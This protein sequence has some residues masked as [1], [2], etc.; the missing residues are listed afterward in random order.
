[1][2]DNSKEIPEVAAAI[3][4][5]GTRRQIAFSPTLVQI[6]AVW[7][8]QFTPSHW[9]ALGLIRSP[10]LGG[11]R[12]TPFTTVSVL[13][14][15]WIVSPDYREGAFWRQLWFFVKHY[16]AIKP[17]TGHKV[18]D[19]LDAAFMDSPPSKVGAAIQR[20]Y[21]AGATSLCDFFAAEYGWDDSVTMSKPLARLFQYLN[22]VRARKQDKPILFNPLSDKARSE[23][24]H[25]GAYGR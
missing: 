22:C 4:Q 3:E 24:L 25:R 16:R 7:V 21:Y 12:G 13:E 11:D 14:F 2:Q 5:E 9:V 8:S 19:Y 15:L 18:F 20:S 23:A 6:G 1:M 10:F 17:S